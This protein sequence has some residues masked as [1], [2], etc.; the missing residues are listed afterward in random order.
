MR[1]VANREYGSFLGA[2]GLFT[3]LSFGLK[4]ALQWLNLSFLHA[5]WWLN[6]VTIYRYKPGTSSLWRQSTTLLFCPH[7]DV[8]LIY[9]G[10]LYWGRPAHFP[11]DQQCKLRSSGLEF[12]SPFLLFHLK[13][14]PLHFVIFLTFLHRCLIGKSLGYQV[15]F[16][17]CCLP[18]PHCTKLFSPNILQPQYLPL[19]VPGQKFYNS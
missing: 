16:L 15:K 6:Y 3:C 2:F 9:S 5:P 1:K 14:G 19:H 13:R 4:K 17:C 10:G 18:A 11:I 8:Y 12:V 7:F